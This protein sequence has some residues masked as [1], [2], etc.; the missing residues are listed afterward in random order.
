MRYFTRDRPTRQVYEI[1]YCMTTQRK[2]GFTMFNEMNKK[3]NLFDYTPDDKDKFVGTIEYFNEVMTG[4]D[5]D[6]ESQVVPC[7]GCFFFDTVNGAS[8][9]MILPQCNVYIPKHLLKTF[10]DICDDP[11]KVQAVKDG[12]LGVSFHKYDSKKRKNCVGVNLV[13]I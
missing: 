1:I 10:Q 11:E 2:R 13:D 7:H 6:K 4:D 8:G 12:K 9:A 5:D 3:G